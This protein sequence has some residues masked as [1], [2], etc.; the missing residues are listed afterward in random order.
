MADGKHFFL[1]R[2][3]L[4][5]MQLPKCNKIFSTNSQ[6]EWRNLRNG[7]M[8]DSWYFSPDSNNLSQQCRYIS[9]AHRERWA[10]KVLREISQYMVLLTILRQTIKKGN[11][12]CLRLLFWPNCSCASYAEIFR[13]NIELAHK[14]YALAHKEARWEI[15]ELEIRNKKWGESYVS[16]VH[17][18]CTIVIWTKTREYYTVSACKHTFSHSTFTLT[19]AHIY[20]IKPWCKGKTAAE[21]IL[22]FLDLVHS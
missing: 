5:T 2:E 10:V 1:G 13:V 17:Y 11:F 18:L 9:D 20:W 4:S 14:N 3:A 15:G 8:G 16:A 6:P 22:C 12:I 19:P 7:Q 21:W